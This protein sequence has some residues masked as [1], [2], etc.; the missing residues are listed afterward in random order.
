MECLGHMIFLTK[1]LHE[2]SCICQT[3]HQNRTYH[4]T[5]L[6]LFHLGHFSAGQIQLTAQRPGK[7]SLWRRETEQDR[8]SR[9]R[10]QPGHRQWCRSPFTAQVLKTPRNPPNRTG[11]YVTRLASHR[12]ENSLQQEFSIWWN[13]NLK[14]FMIYLHILQKL[15]I[16]W[17][18]F[19]LRNK[20]DIKIRTIS[21][22]SSWQEAILAL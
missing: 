4:F 20:R 2:D 12:S 8:S 1:A 19:L 18:E 6:P 14:S 10:T 3:E 17:E 9:T 22:K 13:F 11:L 21:G 16:N 7:S 15:N 5:L